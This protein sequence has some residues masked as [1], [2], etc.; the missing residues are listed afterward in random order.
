MPLEKTS[1]SPCVANWRGISGRAPGRTTGA[2]IGEDVLAARRRINI[3]DRLD[4]EVDRAAPEDVAREL[5]DHR[6]LLARRDTEVVRQEGDAQEEH[7]QDHAEHGQHDP[8]VVR[9]RRL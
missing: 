2:E 3:R 9:L 6:L 5:R 8:R 7:D 1:R 4:L